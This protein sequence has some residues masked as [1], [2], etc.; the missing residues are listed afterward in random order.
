MADDVLCALQCL[1]EGDSSLFKVKPT[2]SVDIMDLKDLIKEK[3]K[4][5][6]LSGVDAS[7]L[8]LWKVRMTMA[9]DSTT[10]SPAG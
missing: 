4:N 6:V 1:I 3:C 8:T 10:N 7:D 5:G 9:S 2:G